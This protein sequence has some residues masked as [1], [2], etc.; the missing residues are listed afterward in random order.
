MQ[1]DRNDYLAGYRTRTVNQQRAAHGFYDSF[2]YSVPVQKNIPCPSQDKI[3]QYRKKAEESNS[4]A[5]APL[6][7]FI[8]LPALYI[9]IMAA[10]G[11]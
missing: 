3:D 11:R 1:R 4:L 7:I 2:Y 9:F 8:I 10:L 5:Y 6:V